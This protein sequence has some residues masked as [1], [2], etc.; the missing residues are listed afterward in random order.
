M[1]KWHHSEADEVD[2][3]DGVAEARLEGMGNWQEAV[4]GHG[5]VIDDSTVRE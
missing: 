5:Q 3:V 4:L 1:S 2:E